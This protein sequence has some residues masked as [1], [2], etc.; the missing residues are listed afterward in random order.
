MVDEGERQEA[1]K[2]KFSRKI[3]QYA[4][5][6]YARFRRA[7]E[8]AAEEGLGL[9]AGH[10]L[11]LD[12]LPRFSQLEGLLEVSIGHALTVDALSMG[13]PAAVTAYQRALGKG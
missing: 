11:N 7:A 12:N 5:P 6:V 10:D 13:L 8:V 1:E 2:K 3:S 9:N 4:I